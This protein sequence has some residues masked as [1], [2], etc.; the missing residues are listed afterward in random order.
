MS[1]NAP[2]PL[3]LSHCW[4]KT[5]ASGHPALPLRDHGIHVGA[6]AKAISERLPAQLKPFLPPGHLLLTAAHDIGKL[7]PGFLLKS[8]VWKTQWQ[9]SLGLNAPKI[10][11]GN[12]AKLTQHFLG[13]ETARPST[14][15][16]ALGGHHGTYP[17]VQARVQEPQ[18]AVFGHDLDWVVQLRR[19]LLAEWSALFGPLP[20]ALPPGKKDARLHWFTGFVIFSDWLGSNTTWFPLSTKPAG[21]SDAQTAAGAALN[22]IG[23]DRREVQ[24]ARSFHHLFGLDTM[25]PLQATLLDCADRPGLYI[26]E[27]PMGEG[28]T[29]AALAA[30]YRRWTEGGERGLYFALPTQLTSNRI[31]DR[32][33]AFLK[34]CVADEAAF[35]LI[36][37][38]AWLQDNRIAALLPSSPDDED[39][40]IQAGEGNRWFADNR[41]ALLAPFGVGTIDQA[42]MAVV[43]ARF[44]AL[45]LF[46]LAGKVVVIDE[47]H[48]YD[49]YTSALVDR[50]VQWLLELGGTVII[51]SATLTRERR[52]SLIRAAGVAEDTDSL[53]YPLV[54]KAIPGSARAEAIEIPAPAPKPKTVEVSV[55]SGVGSD[56]MGEVVRAV[57][58]G[59]CVLVVRNTVDLA[60]KTLEKLRPRCRQTGF[61]SA[62]LHSRFTQA[63]RLANEALWMD[64]LGRD[65]A[66]RPTQGALLVGTQV[67]EQ[68]VD[69]DADFLVTDLAPTDLLLQRL[70]RLHRHDRARPKGHETPRCLIL[71]PEV[72]WQLGKKE[73]LDQLK[74]H[75]FIYPAFSLYMAG[76]IWRQKSRIL[77]PDEIRATL[78]A[79]VLELEGLPQAVRELHEDLVK[80]ASEM[81]GTTSSTDV[82]RAPALSDQEGV[83]TRWNLQPTAHVVLLTSRP[84]QQEGR[85]HLEFPDGMHR[86]LIEG[87]F[88]FPTA[89]H[90]H[91]HA[92]RVPRY[93]VRDL[94]PSAPSWLKD[95]LPDGVLMVRGEDAK[96][97]PCHG[98]GTPAFT[99]RY[100]PDYG[101]LHERQ[102]SVPIKYNE[103][104]DESWF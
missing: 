1:T 13:M 103:D 93:L 63:D 98:Q 71:A 85:I 42:L 59:A 60:Q 7:S 20:E 51:L 3:R 70:G 96:L 30:A 47:V 16:L 50:L 6:V 41:R 79:S 14:L 87:I 24:P 101:L 19:E 77:L 97:I 12:H 78:E 23:W 9:T 99:F 4:A 26:V 72:D 66:H 39:S 28:K 2:P 100:L 58:A 80:K 11:E 82:F 74:P 48:S 83:Q 31:H 38:K 75:R 36:H 91:L 29:E 46:G 18:G 54:T 67:V 40:R 94:Q 35:A 52:G 104:E 10:Y 53:A 37:G 81:T 43:A 84:L 102:S 34:N 45:R 69:I 25:R 5:D 55:T 86:S 89:R 57:E 65:G 49:A 61:V 95:Y 56:W 76:Q 17:Y 15:L 73:V 62:C 68:S 88:D 32:V 44:S 92:I 22:D 27:A 8:A 21:V 64:R 33:G 90:L